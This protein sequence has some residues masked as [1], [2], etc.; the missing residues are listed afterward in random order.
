MTKNETTGR[1]QSRRLYRRAHAAELLDGSIRML[2]R[3]ERTGKM[4]PKRFTPP[5]THFGY[6]MNTSN[7]LDAMSRRVL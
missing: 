6:T 4:S 7:V 5:P 1:K 3:L 2:K